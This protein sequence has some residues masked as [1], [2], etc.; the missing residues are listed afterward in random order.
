MV[1]GQVLFFVMSH[2]SLK[3]VFMKLWNN[4][5]A[6]SL[7]R[8]IRCVIWHL[9]VCHGQ[10]SVCTQSVKRMT[11]CPLYRQDQLCTAL[12]PGKSGTTPRC[13]GPFT[14]QNAVA[15]VSLYL[16]LSCT[17]PVKWLVLLWL[18]LFVGSVSYLK[19]FI[20]PVCFVLS[21]Q[22][23]AV[24]L[25]LWIHLSRSQ[26]FKLSQCLCSGTGWC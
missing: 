6:E 10:C 18:F 25:D 12:Q 23:A 4:L 9:F 13:L 3:P 7:D 14:H 19:C 20:V 26:H 8:T 11:S 1:R 16:S 21:C 17:Q 15:Y 24:H 22:T 2:L 5:K